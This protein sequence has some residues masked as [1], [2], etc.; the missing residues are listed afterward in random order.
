M[1]SMHSLQLSQW[2]C[3]LVTCLSARK[4]PPSTDFTVFCVSASYTSANAS[5]HGSAE[6]TISSGRAPLRKRMGFGHGRDVRL[7]KREARPAPF[8][9]RV[10]CHLCFTPQ[11]CKLCNSVS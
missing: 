11:Q 3:M 4:H 8:A 1:I 10:C 5:F 6:C 9:I 7:T 2:P